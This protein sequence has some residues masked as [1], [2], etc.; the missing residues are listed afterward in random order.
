MISELI[1]GI[2]D[3]FDTE[4]TL[5]AAL[6]G[7]LFYQ[8]APDNATMPFGTYNFDGISRDE[9]MGAA[10][11]RIEQVNCRIQLYCNNTDGGTMIATLIDKAVTCFDWCT[12][13]VTGY[14]FLKMG[15]SIIAPII[16]TDEIWQG[17]LLYDIWF[18]TT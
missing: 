9:I 4:N 10:T 5:Q 8:A 16:Y 11:K 1:T 7:G 15:G 13:M 12:L 3:R 6:T 18:S 14:T 2:Y 17:T